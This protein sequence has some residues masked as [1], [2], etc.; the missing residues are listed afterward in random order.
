MNVRDIKA[1]SQDTGIDPK[2]PEPYRA[3]D[4]TNATFFLVAEFVMG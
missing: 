3:S 4:G 2:N 1:L